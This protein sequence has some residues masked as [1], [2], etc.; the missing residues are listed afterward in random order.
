VFG[1]MP[2]VPMTVISAVLLITV[3]SITS[4]PNSTT[5]RRYFAD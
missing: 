4:K 3:S 2:V 1:L 5:L